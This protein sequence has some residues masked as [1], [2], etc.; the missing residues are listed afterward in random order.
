MSTFV[1]IT[2]HVCTLN[3]VESLL[4]FLFLPGVF[5]NY[6]QVKMKFSLSDLLLELRDPSPKRLNYA[7]IRRRIKD[8]W[9][10]WVEAAK[11]LLEKQPYIENRPAK[12]VS[13]RS[14]AFKQRFI[15]SNKHKMQTMNH[16][17]WSSGVKT[18]V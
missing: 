13:H 16:G 2:C 8:M 18:G 4:F 3:S 11:R 7:F 12:Q 6:I 17:P 14:L 5:I 10:R 1:G 15:A 9:S